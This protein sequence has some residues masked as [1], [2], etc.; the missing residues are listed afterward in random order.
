MTKYKTI[1]DNYRIV[2]YDEDPFTP[3]KLVKRS[4]RALRHTLIDV[5]PILVINPKDHPSYYVT[6]ISLPYLTSVELG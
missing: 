6:S 5:E 3:L 1:F 2:L 4:E